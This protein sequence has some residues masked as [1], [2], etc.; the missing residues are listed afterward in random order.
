MELTAQHPQTDGAKRVG[1]W[2]RVSTH[3]Q[4]EGD[5][6]E[7]HEQRARYYAEAKGWQVVTVYHLEAVSGKSV[8]HHSEAER[9]LSDI[10]N[11]RISGLIFSKLARL[12]RNT[13]ELLDMADIFKDL[14]ADLISLAEAIDTSSPAGR[15]FFTVQA[16]L[17]QFEREEI[18]ERVA[19]SVPVRARLG[20]PLGGAAP[21][22]Y[23]WHERRLIIDQSEAPVRRLMYELYLQHRRKKTVARLLNEAGHRTRGGGRFSDTTVDRLLRD[24]IAKGQ[25]R[26]N[27]TRSL[28]EKKHW[29]MKPEDQWVFIGVEPIVSE[30]LWQQCSEILRA[31]KQQ[32]RFST[33]KPVHLFAGLA[34][35]QCGTKLYVPSNSPK[36]ICFACRNKIPVIDLEEV[37][38]KEL[39]N[40]FLS[41]KEIMRYMEKADEALSG[42]R[43]LLSSLTAKAKQMKRDMDKLLRLYLDEQISGEGFGAQYKPL[44]EQ[45]EAIGEQMPILQGEI[46]HLE[47]ALFAPDG[48]VETGKRIYLNWG[49]LKPEER[50]QIVEN[51]VEKV[52]VGTKD[53]TIELDYLPSASAQVAKGQHNHKGSSPPRA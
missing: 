1:I 44:E 33:K 41:P 36:Y 7:H 11:K 32:P 35:C 5:S 4:A 39:Q 22:G 8:M 25:R 2:V 47:R 34:Y 15:M 53:I 12:A 37:Y 52:V 20:K 40:F 31:Q 19:A 28:G 10:Q 42:K 27:Y 6:P 26:A 49:N 48:M 3:D 24:P 17:T 21:F 45:A 18:A 38:C 29:V 43:A 13:K 23:R 9:M 14:G 30:E 51:T 46:E 16:A 50:R